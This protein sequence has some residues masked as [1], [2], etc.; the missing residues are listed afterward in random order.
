MVGV[1]LPGS[2]PPQLVGHDR[3]R[4]SPR[5]RVVRS[6]PRARDSAED[7]AGVHLGRHAYLVDVVGPSRGPIGYDG[8][9]AVHG[10]VHAEVVWSGCT[11][12]DLS[13][14]HLTGAPP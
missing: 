7:V 4:R 2:I 8:D 9:R 1:V 6:G 3:G 14:G 11:G 5:V 10:K 12:R 13:T